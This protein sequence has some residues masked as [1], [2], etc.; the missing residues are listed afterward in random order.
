MN[1]LVNSK[2]FDLDKGLEDSDFRLPPLDTMTTGI[3]A[4]I[5]MAK[6]A[7]EE[8]YDRAARIAGT[9]VAT[10]AAGQ[11]CELAVPGSGALCRMGAKALIEKL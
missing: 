2:T 6:A 10:E 8:D 4:A 1:T 7:K 3:S 11:L 5:E 9:A